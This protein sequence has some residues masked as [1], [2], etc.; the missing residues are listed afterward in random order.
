MPGAENR[1]QEAKTLEIAAI[2]KTKHSFW[3]MT[4]N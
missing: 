4:L 3:I 2:W 1:A